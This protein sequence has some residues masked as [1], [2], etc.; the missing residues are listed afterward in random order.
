MKFNS[1]T[2]YTRSDSINDIS[3]AILFYSSKS[4]KF[5]LLFKVK[6]KV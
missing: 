6:E 3:Q 4:I 1:L 2:S 5:D